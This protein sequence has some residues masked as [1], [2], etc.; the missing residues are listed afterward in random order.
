[1]AAP[2]AEGEA[3]WLRSAIAAGS[4]DWYGR[5]HPNVTAGLLGLDVLVRRSIDWVLP[6]VCLACRCRPASSPTTLGL[7]ARCRGELREHHDRRCIC[8]GRSLR[9]PTPP[10]DRRCGGC[11]RAPPPWQRLFTLWDY[12]PPA[13]EVLRALKFLRVE[14]LARRI[15]EQAWDRHAEEMVTVDALVPIPLPWPRRM[16]RG[17]NQT[18]AIARPLA[19]RLGKDMVRPLRRA[20]SAA[21]SGSD[22]AER[23]RRARRSFRLRSR[24]SVPKRVLLVDDVFTT[25]ATL[26]V[27]T[28]L[29]RR[30]GAREVLALAPFWTPPLE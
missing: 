19:L 4:R 14:G 6:P 16:V 12:A 10:A 25:G 3:P 24:A 23:R 29:L 21:M 1:M 9:S 7:C 13:D 11:R 27:A 15:A 20:P 8:C 17:F 5:D 18:E 2:A 22:P 30:G 28:R 26:T